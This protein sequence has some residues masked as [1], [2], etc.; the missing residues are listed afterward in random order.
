MRC[1]RVLDCLDDHVDG[2]LDSRNAEAIR[3]HMDECTD[4]REIALAH[5]AASTS[6]SSWDDAEPPADC[7]DKILSRL[8]ALPVEAFEHRSAPR[9]A[10]ARWRRMPSIE[11]V[12][13]RR[14]TTAGLAAAATV[15]AAAVAFRTDTRPSRHVRVQPA[16][17][18]AVTTASWFQD[19]Y[20]F[21]DGLLRSPRTSAPALRP[22]RSAAQFEILGSPR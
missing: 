7:F 9:P 5:R 13:I 1:K 19:G 2:L 17:P 15:L 11:G 14:F 18:V 16:A 22:I 12:D 4:C 10:L 8:E 21:D 3:D 6:L 20:D